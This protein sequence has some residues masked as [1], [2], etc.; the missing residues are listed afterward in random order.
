MGRPK[1]SKNK[2]KKGVNDETNKQVI[3]G[4]SGGH[5]SSL[6]ISILDVTEEI[7]AREI[8]TLIYSLTSS[9]TKGIEFLSDYRYIS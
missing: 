4:S 5:D 9:R 2:N 8:P 1:G 3:H 6:G 7:K